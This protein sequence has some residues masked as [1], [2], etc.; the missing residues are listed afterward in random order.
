M[1]LT[2]GLSNSCVAKTGGLAKIWLMNADELTTAS[3]VEGSNVWTT[4]VTTGAAHAFEF[5]LDSAEYRF[6]QS[7]ENGSVKIEHELELFTKGLSELQRA[8]LQE[9]VEQ[10][11]GLVAIA[12]DN[13]GLKFVIG[14]STDFTNERPLYAD[15]VAG[16]SGKEMTDL[17]G[18][19]IIL[20]SVDNAFA[21]TTDLTDSAV[22]A[23]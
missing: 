6:S 2:T 17:V 16:G 12:K 3:W 15:S 21:K 14:Y 18:S 7:R 1:G 22:D 13:E 5:E 9:L 11:C 10:N 4:I 23:L 8:S 20:K 19:T